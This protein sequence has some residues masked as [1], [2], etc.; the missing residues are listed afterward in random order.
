MIK[1]HE[2]ILPLQMKIHNETPQQCRK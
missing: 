1:Y 2:M